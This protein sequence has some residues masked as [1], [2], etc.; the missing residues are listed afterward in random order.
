[1]TIKR[2]VESIGQLCAILALAVATPASAQ[3]EPASSIEPEAMAAMDRMSAA[4][5]A[6]PAFSF[7]ADVTTE[8]VLETGQ[9]LQ[10]GGTL[11]IAAR[12][13]N[14]FR[15]IA[16]SDTT[17][18]EFFYDGRSLTIF[19]P[20]L[21][22]YTQVAAPDSI[23]LTLEKARSELGIE[24]PLAD[25]FVWDTDQTMRARVRSAFAVRP[26]TVGDRSCF[27]YAFRQAKVDWQIW[28]EEGER[29]LPCKFVVTNTDDPSLPQYVAVLHWSTGPQLADADFTFTPPADAK[30][31]AIVSQAAEASQGGAK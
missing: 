15:I 12:K 2:P 18:R 5:R 8:Q 16:K 19:A 24:I 31:I 17:N 6:I 20:R 1:M 21:G 14:G 22:Y 25:L 28:I 11:Q 3:S 10:F 29:A 7:D 23:G 30:R 13:P 27:H 9:K 4:L 26:E